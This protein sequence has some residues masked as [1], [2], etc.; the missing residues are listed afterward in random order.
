MQTLWIV[1]SIIVVLSVILSSVLKGKHVKQQVR[2]LLNISKQ[3]V[4]KLLNEFRRKTFHL[5][6]LLVPGIYYFGLKWDFL[7][8]YNA[9]LIVGLFA[10]SALSVD[11]RTHTNLL[12]FTHP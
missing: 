7:E 9:T 8:K 2:D 11:V 10:I 1:L 5:I 6:G 3:K 4:T 12:L